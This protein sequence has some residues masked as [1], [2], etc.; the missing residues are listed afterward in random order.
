MHIINLSITAQSTKRKALLVFWGSGF[1]LVKCF[2]C[3]S[4]GSVMDGEFGRQLEFLIKSSRLGKS[5]FA[6]VLSLLP[7]KDILCVQFLN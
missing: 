2:S 5:E 4:N 6:F 1:V 3:T 7:I